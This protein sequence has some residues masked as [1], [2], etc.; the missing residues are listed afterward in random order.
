VSATK[1]I[2]EMTPDE[3]RAYWR[4]NKAKNL[5]RQG[6]RVGSHNQLRER[7]W[8]H[9][10]GRKTLRLPQDLIDRFDNAVA[11]AKAKGEDIDVIAAGENAIT[12][13]VGMMERTHNN[14]QPFPKVEKKAIPRKPT[15]EIEEGQRFIWQPAEKHGAGAKITVK[16]VSVRGGEVWIMASGK[17]GAFWHRETEFRDACVFAPIAAPKKKASTRKKVD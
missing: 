5:K 16:K 4:D 15:G 13:W 9:S 17:R 12:M 1:K 14:G 10:Y 8:W 3:R 2:S 6:V 11:G 7:G